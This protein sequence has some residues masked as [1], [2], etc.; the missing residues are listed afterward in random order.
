MSL[1]KGQDLTYLRLPYTAFFTRE[2]ALG[3]VRT[4]FEKRGEGLGQ[5]VWPEIEDF[6]GNPRPQ[7]LTW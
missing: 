7:I 6:A 5:P 4:H 3:P 1:S 2:K